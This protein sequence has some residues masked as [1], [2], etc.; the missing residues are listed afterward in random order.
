MKQKL[1]GSQQPV[2]VIFLKVFQNL[3]S[4]TKNIKGGLLVGSQI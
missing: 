4:N 1:S 3:A 2:T